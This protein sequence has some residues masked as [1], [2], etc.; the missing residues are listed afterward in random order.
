MKLVTHRCDSCLAEASTPME[1]GPHGYISGYAEPGGDL[2]H[3]W[4]FLHAH[5]GAP[6]PSQSELAG[7]MFADLMTKAQDAIEADDKEQTRRVL[8]DAF[9]QFNTPGGSF[10]AL[11]AA[12][13]LHR[14]LHLCPACVAGKLVLTMSGESLVPSPAP[15]PTPEP[16]GV[17]D[18]D[19][20]ARAHGQDAPPLIPPSVVE[21]PHDPCAKCGAAIHPPYEIGYCRACGEPFE[22]PKDLEGWTT[23]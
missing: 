2:P 7:G 8:T 13:S 20:E 9:K 23:P 3:G 11:R 5:V 12:Q 4:L 15:A 1:A 18:A 21:T 22:K 17:I 6:Q 19:F 10:G 16:L 14:D